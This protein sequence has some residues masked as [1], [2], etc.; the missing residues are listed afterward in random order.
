[1]RKLLLLNVAALCPAEVDPQRT[2]TLAALADRGTLSPLRA[3]FPSL[4]CTSHA[5]M[6]T[7]ALP[8]THGVVGNGWYERHHARVFMWNRSAHQV[9]GETI[10]DAA[11]ARH[12][13][14]KV[15]NLFWRFVADSSCDL[16]VTERPVYWTSGRKTFDFYTSPPSL[17]DRLVARHGK[18]PFMHFWGPFAGLKS[19]AW[20][21]AALEQ[22]MREDDPDLLLGYAPYLDYEGQRHGPESAQAR[23]AL[24]NMDRALG[25]LLTAA[26]SSGRDVALVSDYGFKQVDQPVYINR[27]LRK[28][29]YVSIEEA[30]NGDQIEAGKSRAFAVC[31]NQAAHVY[32]ADAD[33]IEPVRKLLMA[34]AGISDVLDREAQ[35]RVGIDH[36][37][38][39]E[40]VAA[41]AP[42]AWFAYPYWL[43]PERAPD[44]DPCIAIFD[45]AGFDPC[46]LFPPPG[47]FGKLHIA[48]RVMQKMARLAVPFD[49][50]NPDATLP[51]GARNIAPEDPEGA[52]L[53]TRWS[54]DTATVPMQ[55]LKSL[56]LARMFDTE[57]D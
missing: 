57:P 12:P 50:I 15:A 30:A 21:L 32:V 49:V 25:A 43:Q 3:P 23:D 6:V 39:G 40:L 17:H 9:G 22:V 24:T 48:L 54:R 44:F 33:D 2:P 7:G 46:E 8:A 53:I 10:W 26:Q 1:M 34:T 29:G 28:A 14:L 11:R 13:D 38:S 41:A 4:T 42:N 35:A 31:D 36:E 37:R 47:A 45:K 55:D 19:T 20:I 56:L 5:T 51:R 27:E 18:F 52:V 16:Q